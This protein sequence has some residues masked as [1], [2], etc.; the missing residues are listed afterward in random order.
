MNISSPARPASPQKALSGQPTTIGHNGS[1][2]ARLETSK[3]RNRVSRLLLRLTQLLA[4][5]VPS[6]P[7]GQVVPLS[8]MHPYIGL[9]KVLV[10]VAAHLLILGLAFLTSSMPSR[11]N[12]VCHPV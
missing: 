7:T 12:S 3:V 4:L 1:P 5:I 10:I 6:L 8:Q 11:P 9:L 2:G